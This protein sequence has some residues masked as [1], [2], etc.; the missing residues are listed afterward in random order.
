MDYMPLHAEQDAN[1]INR[2][3]RGISISVPAGSVL[4]K[5]QV[6]W[7]RPMCSKFDQSGVFHNFFCCFI[8]QMLDINYEDVDDLSLNDIDLTN[9]ISKVC[10]DENYNLGDISLIFCSDEYLLDMNRTHL[11][12]DY[13]TDI[14]TF[15]YTDNQIVSGDLFISIDRVRDNASDFNVS[16]HHELHRVIIH[17]VLHLCGYKDKSDDEEKLMRTKENNALSLISFT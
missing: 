16:F 10:V 5:M 6:R 2:C 1:V 3:P 15:D 17:G 12:H 9:W 13:Y 7:L 4:P 8:N 11:D 14:I